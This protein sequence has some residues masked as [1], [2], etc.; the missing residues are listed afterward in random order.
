VSLSKDIFSPDN[1]GVDD[2]LSINY[3]FG[4]PGYTCTVMVFDAGGRPVKTIAHKE[5]V[6]TKGSFTWDGTNEYG[7]KTPGGLY[8]IYVE[9]VSGNGDVKT[10]KLNVVVA[11][12]K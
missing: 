9:T 6:D 12:K 10:Y 11:Y 8:L 3:N 1:D 5:T 2:I 4:E 7:I